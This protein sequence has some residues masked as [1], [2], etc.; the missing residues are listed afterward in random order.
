M[1]VCILTG[2][3]GMGHWMASLSLRQQILEGYPDAQV[4]IVDFPAYAAPRIAEAWYKCFHLMVSHGSYLFNLYY[5]LTSL[6]HPDARPPFEGLL[7][8]R[9]TELLAAKRPD[10][11][12][13]THP[14]CAQLVSRLKEKAGSKKKAR[15]LE[16]NLARTD[17]RQR[18]PLEKRE[19]VAL[20][21][22]LITCV[23]DVTSHPEWINR[24]TD[25]YLVPS[26]EVRLGLAEKGV[27]PALV[28]V[29]GIPV[30]KEFRHLCHHGG[31]KQRELLIMGGGLGLLPRDDAFYEALDRIPDT[32][33]TL[34]TGHNCRLYDHLK[35]RFANIQ[36]I[37]YTSQVWDYMEKADLI[38]TKPGGITL[39]ESI[40]AQ[41]PILAWP[42]ALQQE[43]N[44]AR[45]MCEAGIGWVAQETDCA[46]RI[47]EILLDRE[48]LARARVR[49]GYLKQQ[50]QMEVLPGLMKAV[51]RQQV[52]HVQGGGLDM[53]MAM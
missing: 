33:T 27:D 23:T 37:G 14:L 16:R 39:F 43:C 52:V 46:C 45:W 10:V 20:D 35:D 32:H 4:E 11:V 49:M 41:V 19:G 53:C 50:L 7:L 24:N 38:V 26:K 15:W 34:I 29:T 2:K 17:H 42:P 22:P 30:R 25:C 31:E 40:F 36:V 28:C 5:K 3:F 6:G 13:A 21:L 1:N 44:N 48:Q 51:S 18:K 47:R 12:I 8:D 9:L